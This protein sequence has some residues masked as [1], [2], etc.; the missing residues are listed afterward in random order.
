MEQKTK[1]AP[2]VMSIVAEPGALTFVTRKEWQRL[3]ECCLGELAQHETV[4]IFTGTGSVFML[5]HTMDPADFLLETGHAFRLVKVSIDEETG[6]QIFS[7]MNLSRAEAEQL[8]RNRLT[9]WE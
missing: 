2:D 5:L 8:R 7:I 9:L 6:K 4:M 3:P 1:A